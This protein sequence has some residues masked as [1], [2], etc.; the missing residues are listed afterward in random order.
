MDTRHI[1]RAAAAI[2][3]VALIGGALPYNGGSPLLGTAV[4]AHAESNVTFDEE[5]GL[6][7]LSGNITKDDLKSYRYSS[8]VKKIVALE[9]TVLP[10]DCSDLFSFFKA[11]SIDLSKAYTGRVHNMRRMFYSCEQLTELNISGF[12]TSLVIDMSSMFQYCSKLTSLDVSS[13]STNNVTTMEWMFNS[14]RLLTELDVSSFD[15]VHV[16]SFDNMFSGCSRLTSLDV[17]EFQ[18]RDAKTFAHM[19]DSCSG[20]TSIDV[21]RFDTSSATNLYGMFHN[22]KKLESLDLSNF[23]TSK[24]TNMTHL[25]SGSTKLREI[26]FGNFDTSAVTSMA[27]MFNSCSSL[28]TLDLRFNTSNVTNMGDMFSECSNL[29]QLYLHSFDTSNVTDMGYMFSGCSVLHELDLNNFNTEKVMDMD[30]MFNGCSD[31]KQLYLHS[32]DT[33]NVTDMDYMFNGCTNLEELDISSFDT[34]NVKITNS[35]FKN[36]KKLGY[37]DFSGFDLSNVPNSKE[38]FTGCDAMKPYIVTAAANNATLNSSI[39]LNFYITRPERLDKIVISGPNGDVET[40]LS[41]CEMINNYYKITYP[42]NASQGSSDVTMKAYDYDGNRLIVANTS[43]G[44]L[45][46]S[47][48]TTT[49]DNYLAAVFANNSLSEEVRDLANRLRRLC[50]AAD[51]YFNDTSAFY[52]PAN[53]SEADKDFINSKKLKNGAEKYKI[54][55]VLNSDTAIRFYYDGEENTADFGGKTI[56]AK[57]GKYGKYFEIPDIAAHQLFNDYT[58]RIGNKDYVLNTMSYVQRV[59]E[60]G[61]LGSKLYG[62]CEMFYAYG[63]AAYDYNNSLKET[64]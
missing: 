41:D 32:F 8:K 29:K 24:V 54:S 63:K 13:F 58:I 6:L 17:T 7:T 36:C 26:I 62:V 33:S 37:T 40:D 4:V 3:A 47:Q 59:F 57:T 48:S 14:C 25:F 31:L 21:S 42:L 1:R 23:N 10:D 16:T 30:R 22:C 20:L 35:M 12:D 27:Y 5:T 2:L 43:N 34:S 51:G 45:D 18:T 39:G 52:P 19:F 15:T 49:L 46:H 64:T 60:N 38:M 9:G 55:V 53:L 61:D 50:T 56:T 28:E 11:E 44:L